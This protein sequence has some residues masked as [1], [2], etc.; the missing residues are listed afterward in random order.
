VT[1]GED[2]QDELEQIRDELRALIKL[3]TIRWLTPAEEA[4]YAQL[5]REE[6][7]LLRDRDSATPD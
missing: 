5:G 4:R 2:P 6:L 1:R 7:R 3:R